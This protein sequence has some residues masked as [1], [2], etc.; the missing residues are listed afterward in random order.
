VDFELTRGVVL[1]VRPVDA[2]TG[3]PLAGFVEYFTFA[4]NPAY[5]GLKGFTMPRR[6][7]NATADGGFR[8]VAPPGPGLIAFRAREDRYP[9]G[10]G[11]EK[12]QD[13]TDR[14]LIQ[15]VPHLV[16]VWNYHVLH[17]VELKAGAQT[18]DVEFKLESGRTVKG[19]VLDPD[20]KPLAGAQA[21]GLKS[22]PTAFGPWEGEPLKTAGF[23]AVAVDPKRPRAL[24][25]V[26][27]EKKLAGMVRVRGDEKDPVEVKLQPWATVTGRLVDA[28][29][30]P[31]ADVRLGFVQN[32]DE[33]DPSGV[34][35]LPGARELHTDAQGRFTLEGF[36]PGLRYNLVA[37]DSRR[38]LASI[39]RNMTL[40]AGE[41][42][43]VGNV[44]LR[45]PE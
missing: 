23:E 16:H 10:V 41:A 1:T 30:K 27:K 24:V 39:G 17:P 9:V 4:D 31:Q 26:H 20:G 45:P 32:I 37:M 18:Q 15:T 40:K 12:F 5:Q 29:G 35:D 38:V 3:K 22:S 33:P 11:A 42:K 14:G 13:R 28:D 34:G 43:D 36:A 7:E 21:R 2:G 8:V 19:R 25:F 44:T 6:E